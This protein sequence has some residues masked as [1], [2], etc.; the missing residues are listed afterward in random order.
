M[1]TIDESKKKAYLAYTVFACF[2]TVT[3]LSFK[4]APG[5]AEASA[6]LKC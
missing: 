5:F 3:E 4:G 1:Q 2:C 6:P